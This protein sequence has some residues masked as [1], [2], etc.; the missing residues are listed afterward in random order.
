MTLEGKYI[1]LFEKTSESRPEGFVRN[2]KFAQYSYLLLGDSPFNPD[3]SVTSTSM[4]LDGLYEW[5]GHSSIKTEQPPE[6]E[7]EFRATIARDNSK[8]VKLYD[9]A[10]KG[11]FVL[12]YTSGYEYIHSPNP[13][14]ELHIRFFGGLCA[15]NLSLGIKRAVNLNISFQYLFSLLADYLMEINKL[16]LTNNQNERFICVSSF[17]SNY[18]DFAQKPFSSHCRTP[19]ISYDAIKDHISTLIGNYC[20]DQENLRYVIYASKIYIALAIEDNAIPLDLRNISAAQAL[21]ILYRGKVNGK[22]LR[23]QDGL[24]SFVKYQVNNLFDNETQRDAYVK[25]HLYLRNNIT[26][27]NLIDAEEN[28]LPFDEEEGSVAYFEKNKSLVLKDYYQTICLCLA[29]ILLKLNIPKDEIPGLLK[30]K[31]NEVKRR[32]EYLSTDEQVALAHLYGKSSK[33]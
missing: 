24:D 17:R 9:G 33:Q 6:G 3:L 23:Q 28:P 11:S 20:I 15:E 2:S 13:G 8:Q 16:V 27:R 4:K 25:T 21:E 18:K 29:G 5:Y 1:C 31:I 22:K 14:N 12:S 32:I 19:L 7:L 10:E 30:N 26:H